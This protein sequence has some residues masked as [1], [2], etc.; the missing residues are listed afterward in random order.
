[1]PE[2]RNCYNLISQL[3]KFNLRELKQNRIIEPV[4]DE[5]KIGPHEKG[6]IDS[7]F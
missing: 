2:V 3:L 1:M 6:P 7:R 5:A 4:I